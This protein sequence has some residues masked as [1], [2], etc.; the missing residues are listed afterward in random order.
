MMP[1]PLFYSR[2]FKP[3]A[4]AR[5]GVGDRRRASGLTLVELMFVLLIL[6]VLAG[7]ALRATDGVADQARYRA[8]Q[9]T[10]SN[11]EAAVVGPANL[12]DPDGAAVVTGFVADIGRLPQAVGDDAGTQLQEL[13]EN[14]TNLPTFTVAAPPGDAQVRV[15][16]GWRG[17]YL[18]LGVGATRLTDGWGNVLSLLHADGTTPAGVGEPVAIVRGLG[19]DNITGGSDY[20]ADV[21]VDFE[22]TATDSATAIPPRY[23]GAVTGHVY[24]GISGDNPP[25][26]AN[27]LVVVRLYGP[28]QGRP[29]TVAQF[30]AP[31]TGGVVTYTFD[32]NADGIDDPLA[33][34]PR[35]LRAYLL[36]GTST[37]P[38]P[39]ARLD[40][41]SLAAVSAI[42]SVTV[43]AGG[44]VHDLTLITSP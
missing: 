28:V 39:E 6:A 38:D 42:R 13:W 35:E 18:R 33:I 30:A 15:E 37:A 26:A 2:R 4:F 41:A 27:T 12:R 25:V 31:P 36:S 14:T 7:V 24:Y 23:T 8:T 5:R 19:L 1:V 9:S 10:L 29:A 34:G 11:I 40:T 44:S 22:R 3:P 21:E 20:N 43:L 32:A 17:P 16:A